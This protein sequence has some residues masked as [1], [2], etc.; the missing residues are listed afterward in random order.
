MPNPWVSPRCDQLIPVNK[1]VK[2]KTNNWKNGW[3]RRETD[4]QL[5]PRKNEAQNLRYFFVI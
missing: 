2:E 4:I 3:R 1:A 5:L